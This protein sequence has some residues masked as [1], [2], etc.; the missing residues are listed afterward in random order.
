MVFRIRV[1]RVI[2][3]LMRSRQVLV[4]LIRDII[5]CPLRKLQQI[6]IVAALPEPERKDFWKRALVRR[7]LESFWLVV[8]MLC[9]HFDLTIA[10]QTFNSC[11][12]TLSVHSDF[13]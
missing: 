10:D 12:F 5:N 11:R 3:Q 2:L 4:L 7:L 1:N 8:V 6:P 13:T 9:L